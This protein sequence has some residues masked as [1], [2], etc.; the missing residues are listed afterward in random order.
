MTSSPTLPIVAWG[1][2]VNLGRRQHYRTQAM[3]AA[4]AL[5]AVSVL[6]KA[7][8]SIV[9]LECVVATAGQSGIAKG[10]LSPYYYRARPEML[11]V[12][13]AAGIDVVTTANNHSGDYGPAALAEQAALLDALG[14]GHTGSGPTTDAA[15]APLFRRA[16]DV[17]VA[18]FAID[19]TQP[20][21]AAGPARFGHAHLPLGSPAAWTDCLAPR[22]ASARREA[23]VVLVALHWGPN[24]EHAPGADEIAVGHALID[25][26]ADAILGASAH[27]LQGVEIYKGR[28]I[29]HDAGDLLFDAITRD[30]DE[31]GVFSLA[32]DVTGVRRVV[33]TPIQ[34]G[35]G[36]SVQREGPSADA[37]AQRFIDKSAA[38]GAQ[39][40]RTTN[41]ECAIDLHPPHR[42]A[43]P[44]T[45]ATPHARPL[46]GK[47]VY[48]LSVIRPAA[49]ARPEWQVRELPPGARL[50]APVEIGPLRLLGVRAAPTELTRRRMLF[51]E[52]FWELREPTPHDWRLDVRATPAP[53]STM[54]GWGRHMDHDPCDW[55]WPTSRWM[56]GTIYRD[57]HGLRAPPASALHD[58]L[59]RFE[60]GLVRAGRRLPRVALPIGLRLTVGKP[61]PA[62]TPAPASPAT[63]APPPRYQA[64]A[65]DALPPD[66]PATPHASAQ[67][68]SAAQLAAVT[69][70]TWLVAPPE[71][72]FVR[73]VVRSGGHLGLLPAPA[74]FVASDYETLARHE[75]YSQPQSRHNWDRTQH[76][77]GLQPRLAGAI[78]SGPVAGLAPDFPLL[79]VADPIHALIELGATARQ[80]LRG[81]LVVITGSAGKTSV[82][83][84]LA[85]A[86]SDAYRVFSSID[87]YNSRV[88]MLAMLANVPAQT[89]LVVLEAAI[90]GIN[91]PGFQNI[92]LVQPD[93][94]IITNIA[95][96]HLGAGQSLED[97]AQRKANVFEGMRPGGWVVLCADTAHF[98]DLVQRARQK[99]LQLLTYGEAA[100]SDIRLEAH[101]G[102]TGRVTAG[103][104][105]RH[106]TFTLGA[107]GRHMAVNSLACIAVAVALGFDFERVQQRLASFAA[108]A[109]RGRELHVTRGNARLRVID[110]AYNANPLS[111]AAALATMADTPA[112]QGR[113]IMVLGDM[114]ELGEDSAR[115]HQSLI[116]PIVQAEPARVFLLGTRMGALHAPLAAALSATGSVQAHAALATLE[117]A[118]LAELADGDVLLFK[119]S[120]GM[121]LWQIVERLAAPPQDKAAGAPPVTLPL[122]PSAVIRRRA[123]ATTTSASASTSAS[124]AATFISTPSWALYDLS[125]D[126]LL[127]HQPGNRQFVPA[128]LAKLMTAV[129]VDQKLQKDGLDRRSPIVPVPAQP[130]A[131]AG[132]PAASLYARAPFAT[133]QALLEAALIVSSNKAALTLAEWHSGT[134]GAFVDAMNRQAQA[135]GLRDTRFGDPA[136]LDATARTTAIDMLVLARHLL[137]DHPALMDVVRQTHFEAN[138][139]A[140]ST[141]LLLGRL[142]GV[143]GL[144]TGSL[145]SHGANLICTALRNGRRLISVVLGA[146]DARLCAQQTAQLMDRGFTSTRS[147][148]ATS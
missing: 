119:G 129:L 126:R 65:P 5:A 134:R 32:L 16:G 90:S 19:A 110:E 132:D 30:D 141:N 145:P 147:D 35:F 137:H 75:R 136:G 71:S 52:T 103:F 27:L 50:A 9:N 89:D 93:L 13:T 133:P 21:F 18:I 62:P 64:L 46:P 138:P 72:W 83:S 106:W 124:S 87:N 36:R 118:L 96:A 39:F 7:D 92:R 117:P 56:P 131:A 109:G 114:L 139:E 80:R 77:A 55:M 24:G 94:A 57:L 15:F 67:T 45:T 146:A 144:K 12:L 31:A 78:V 66:L 101:D 143:D 70:G 3:G 54:H 88:G 20:H 10:E 100:S 82:C 43:A 108:V 120:N 49:S 2:D 128:S 125:A 1:G 91:A 69:R 148:G 41:G 140:P 97:I 34:V 33:F 68:W 4:D 6:A 38:L 26:G 116:A 115:Y 112:P 104:R 37:A 17:R 85:H 121:K 102:E 86:F 111:M 25:A 84:L 122:P 40:Q 8:L 98:D 127:T 74:L 142:D 123:A 11:A 58:A 81:K 51:V 53:P 95:P 47:A 44:A 14:I 113:K 61:A 28:P 48:D 107:K 73:S 130:V 23:D 60:V 79:Q 29:V 99:G 63:M 42:E 135:W 105:D 76:I 59:L 22:I